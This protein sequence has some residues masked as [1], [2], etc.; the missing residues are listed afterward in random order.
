MSCSCPPTKSDCVIAVRC[1]FG[2][3]CIVNCDNI[4]ENVLFKQ[5]E[6]KLVFRVRRCTVHHTHRKSRVVVEVNEKF[7]SPC[8]RHDT[9]TVQRIGVR[10]SIYGLGQTQTLVIV[11]ERKCF[12]IRRCGCRLSA[13]SISCSYTRIGN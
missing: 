6:V 1:N 10:H 13:V 8:L 4:A 9:V 2:A 3:A 12:P 5:I 7:V 11:G